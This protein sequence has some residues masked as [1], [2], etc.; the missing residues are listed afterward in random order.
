MS[1]IIIA[2]DLKSNAYRLVETGVEIA[3]R[4]GG[5]LQLVHVMESLPSN[6]GAWSPAQDYKQIVSSMKNEAR[7]QLDALAAYAREYE[8][9]TDV[10]LLFG[11][12]SSALT[13]AVTESAAT[14]LILGHRSHSALHNL[15]GS[16]V[17]QSV[18]K[19]LQLPVLLVPSDGVTEDDAVSDA[20]LSGLV[21]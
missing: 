20:D 2:V 16:S 3:L 18:L 17:S 19:R 1:L 14:F 13:E 4:F 6:A 15:F 9:A 8:V 12:V 10:R 21:H 5:T 11:P 7:S